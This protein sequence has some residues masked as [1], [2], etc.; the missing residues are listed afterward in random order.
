[1]Y[2]RSPALLH[3]RAL[4]LLCIVAASAWTQA[5]AVPTSL[6]PTGARETGDV[7][8]A[9]FNIRY[10]TA[11]DG[12]DR[13]ELRVPR[14]LETIRRLDADVLGL[15]E[16]LHPQLVE[17]AAALPEHTI[18]GVGRDDGATRGE[19]CAI[20]IRDSVFETLDHG[21]FW[22][23]DA[24]ETPGSR[25]YGNTIPR[26]F[27]WAVV[28]RL[29]D[30]T[31]FRVV[32]T[33]LDHRSEPSRDRSVSQLRAW[34]AAAPPADVTVVLGDLNTGPESAAFNALLKPIPPREEDAAQ[35]PTVRLRDA[36]RVHD[37]DGPEPEGTFHAFRGH[38]TGPRID[39]VLVCDGLDVRAAAIDR[40]P[41]GERWPSDHFPVV[42]RVRHLP[43]TPSATPPSTP[44]SAP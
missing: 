14:V 26:V 17:I 22:L 31:T 43:A 12:D 35:R 23:S 28:R 13:W 20:V 42:A 1:M 4:V 38:T 34:L 36:W 37:P 33:H 30:G 9:S 39:F 21:T 32:N 29:L 7:V 40:E 25:S 3:S 16:A 6:P 15:Q 11:D 18:L 8:V 27:T 44:P 2:H 41:V 24:P 5:A 10:G 19:H